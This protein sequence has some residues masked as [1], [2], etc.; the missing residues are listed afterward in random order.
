MLFSTIGMLPVSWLGIGTLFS[1]KY[2]LEKFH[3]H[4]T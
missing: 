2:G 3:N 4:D 1:E